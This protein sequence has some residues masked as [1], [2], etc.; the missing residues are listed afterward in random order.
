MTDANFVTATLASIPLGD[1]L[2]AYGASVSELSSTLTANYCTQVLALSRGTS[3]NG[4][5]DETG[6][7]VE[8]RSV[9]FSAKNS[10]GKTY[11][12]TIPLVSFMPPPIAVL[13][14]SCELKVIVSEVLDRS[15]E[16]S[17]DLTYGRQA[18]VSA[19]LPFASLKV[20]S[21]SQLKVRVSKVKK[22]NELQDTFAE[23]NIAVELGPSSTVGNDL[24]RSL[25]DAVNIVAES[26]DAE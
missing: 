1:L 14:S 16:N 19:K 7:T 24:L 10:D 15:S 2:G 17:F 22:S 6:G 25:F 11:T 5:F 12:I 23:L 26:P 20:K 8:I 21:S 3:A 18:D 13:H 4:D 9:T